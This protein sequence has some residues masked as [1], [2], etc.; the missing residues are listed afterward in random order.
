MDFFYRRFLEELKASLQEVEISFG[1]CSEDMLARMFGS[2]LFAQPWENQCKC[3]WKILTG[4]VF[5][6]VLDFS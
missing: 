2:V 1:R 6:L 4:I 3:I 5:K